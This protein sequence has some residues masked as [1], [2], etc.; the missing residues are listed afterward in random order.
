MYADAGMTRFDL[1]KLA[2]SLTSHDGK[3]V[4][5]TKGA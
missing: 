2:V 4:P 1:Y 5:L 3:V